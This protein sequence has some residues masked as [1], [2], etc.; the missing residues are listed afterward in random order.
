MLMPSN[1]LLASTNYFPPQINVEQAKY[2]NI[3]PILNFGEN[4]LLIP[5]NYLSVS[6]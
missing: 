1:N 5:T 4:H 6:D 3:C 2:I